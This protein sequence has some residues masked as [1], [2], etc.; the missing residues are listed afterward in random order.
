[1]ATPIN[2]SEYYKTLSHT[3]LLDILANPESYQPSAIQAAK[4]EFDNRQLSDREIEEASQPLLDKQA[5]KEKDLEKVKMVGNKIKTAGQAFADT[6][7]PVQSA[8]PSTEKTIN[9]IV[10]SFGILFLYQVISEFSMLTSMFKSVSAFDL[11][12]FFYL[13]PFIIIPIVIFLFWQRKT[14]GW[15]LLVF[16]CIYSEVG[17]LWM[18]LETVGSSL[19]GSGGFDNLFPRPSLISYVIPLIIFGGIL[20]VLCKPT[21]KE[22]FKIDNQKMIGTIV[23][24][25]L[26]TIIFNFAFF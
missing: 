6:M 11:N 5:R 17:I 23:I 7:N 4:V 20:Y 24:S 26:L 2:F 15:I 14:I 25:V 18:F 16:I 3:A 13:L 8:T 22:V 12:T 10:I 21:M 19:S 9:L 1:M